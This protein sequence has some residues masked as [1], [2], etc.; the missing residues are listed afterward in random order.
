MTHSK[1][2]PFMTHNN[3]PLRFRVSCGAEGCFGPALRLMMAEKIV[4]FPSLLLL[5]IYYKW[6]GT[7]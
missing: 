4:K 6:R 2:D 1:S 5:A 7:V 3:T